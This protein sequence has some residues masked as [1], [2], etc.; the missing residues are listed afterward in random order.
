[1]YGIILVLLIVFKRYFC[2]VVSFLISYLF[3]LLNHIIIIIIMP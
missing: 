2:G 1:M 3:A